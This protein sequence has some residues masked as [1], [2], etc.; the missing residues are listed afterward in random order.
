MT[1]EGAME[2]TTEIEDKAFRNEEMPSGLKYPEQ[3][4]F[5]RFRL[6]YSYARIVQMPPEQGKR[7]KYEILKQYVVDVY[8][9]DLLD[10]TAKMWQKTEEARC[11]YRKN[12]TI[13]NA[14][15]LLAKLDGF[16]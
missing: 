12:R 1:V 7:E 6:L 13:E 9:S 11:A 5:L 2:L 3:L 15:K 16:P 8:N 4:L 14:D 10:S